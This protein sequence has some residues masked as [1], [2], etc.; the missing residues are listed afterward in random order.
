[1]TGF[2]RK[3]ITDSFW[4]S[5]SNSGSRFISFFAVI[6]ITAVLDLREYGALVLAMTIT[7]PVDLLSGFGLNAVLVSDIAR[8]RGQRALSLIKKLL[9]SYIAIKLLITTLSVIVMYIF[10]DVLVERFGS[11]VS[12]NF[13]LLI[14]WIF[15][16]M[17]NNIFQIILN[18]YEKFKIL[19]AAKLVEVSTKLAL[20]VGLWLGG[21]INLYWALFAYVAAKLVTDVFFGVAVFRATRELW[22]A[23]S[24]KDSVYWKTISG[25]GKWD[26]MSQTVLAQIDT[27]LRPWIVKFFIGVEGVAIF[28]VARNIYTGLIGVVPIK[29]VLFPAIARHIKDKAHNI[30]L[31]QKA[32]K[33]TFIIYS[34]LAAIAFFAIKPF[35]LIFFPK[36]E[37][38]IL[39]FRI[40]LV[41][42]LVTAMS[43]GQPAFFY[44]YKLQRIVFAFGFI[45]L[46]SLFTLLPLT[47]A[48]YGLPGVYIER[49]IAL[50]IIYM[51]REFYLRRK[52]NIVTW[53]WSH[54]FTYDYYD[55]LLIKKGRDFLQLKFRKT[56][57]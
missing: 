28:S 55:R 16:V 2:I 43:Y 5:A 50:S 6:I 12:D 46:V 10:R 53:R 57:V 4:L 18:A 47:L 24:S 51:L 35:I 27:S 30:I 48:T 56:S 23:R 52:L 40:L 3:I 34:V 8:Y 21:I 29:Q 44:A 25:H 54:L 11:L 15:A 32:T 20:V 13:N 7:A 36:Y 22:S 41:R 37:T 9:T 39:I 33:Y 19:S 14:V 31:A 49:I 45:N 38:S 26:I 1:M 42:M 17:I